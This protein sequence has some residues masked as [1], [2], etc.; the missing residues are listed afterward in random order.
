LF[1]FESHLFDYDLNM[2]ADLIYSLYNYYIW[3]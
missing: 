2:H 3:C 1:K